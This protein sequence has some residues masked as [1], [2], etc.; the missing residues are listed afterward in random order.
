M[1]NHEWAPGQ[2]RWAEC[3]HPTIGHYEENAESFKEGT[4]DHDVSQNLDA[5]LSALELHDSPRILDFGCGPGRDLLELQR[6]GARPTGL[7]GSARFCVMAAEIAGCPVLHQDFTELELEPASFEGVFANA[8]LFHIP[9]RAIH[10][11]LRDLWTALVPDGV[12]FASM[13]RGGDQEGWNGARYGTYYSPERWDGLLAQA[14]FAVEHS[15]Y[16]PPGKPRD[17]QPWYATVARK[18]LPDS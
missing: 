2:S 9:S 7:D 18:V 13:P 16:R 10:A 5:L 11:V 15:Y 14:G 3:T 4:W 8:T 6:R 12:L 1:K 17:E